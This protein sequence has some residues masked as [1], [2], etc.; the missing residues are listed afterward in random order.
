MTM[1]KIAITLLASLC[2][3]LLYAQDVYVYSSTGTAEVQKGKEW[4]RLKKRDALSANDMVRVSQN[5]SLTLLDKKAEKIYAI[6][7]SAAKQLSQ[8]L[9][10]LKG[11]QQNVTAQFFNHAMKSMFNGGADRI[12]H[13]AAGCTYR[14]DIVE[15]DIAKSLFAKM[16]GNSLKG[17]SN[18]KTDFAVTFELLERNGGGD[19]QGDAK[20]GAQ[21]IFRMKNK[22]DKPMYVNVLDMDS[23][24]DTY[25]CL[26]MDD[27][28]TMSH[29]L[30]PAESTIDLVDFPIEFTEPAGQE[31]MVLIATEEPYDLR[32]VNKYLKENRIK[33]TS[34]YPIGLYAKDFSVKE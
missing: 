34:T 15:N 32:I 26:P 20:I 12:S 7:Q 1:K 24:G 29:L 9:E 21:A 4:V 27:A 19:I 31:R 16:N 8:L 5:S 25:V 13:E 6:P 28:Q 14:G 2:S 10:E 11:K 22:S 23:N 3:C 30:I 17:A 33:Q 18:E